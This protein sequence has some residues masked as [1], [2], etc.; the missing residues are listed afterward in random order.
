MTYGLETH[1]AL[2]KERTESTRKAR[3]YIHQEGIK[4]ALAVADDEDR[5]ARTDFLRLLAPF[6]DRLFPVDAKQMYAHAPCG[7]SSPCP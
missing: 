1:G 2:A 5:P 6:S 3:R 7:T 4:Y